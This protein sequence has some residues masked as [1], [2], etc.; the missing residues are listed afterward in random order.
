MSQKE[1][2]MFLRSFSENWGKHGKELMNKYVEDMLEYFSESTGQEIS[3]DYKR[4][5]LMMLPTVLNNVGLISL[6]W[7]FQSRDEFIAKF[8][9]DLNKA[10][11]KYYKAQSD[12]IIEST[13]Y[14]N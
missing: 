7:A 8:F 6:G 2:E 10:V 14:T 1:V 13:T 3:D 4:N 5:A 12:K 9:Q 11:V